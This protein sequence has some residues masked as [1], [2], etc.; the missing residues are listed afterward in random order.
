MGRV[1]NQTIAED[2]L[3][4]VFVRVWQHI[5]KVS[6]MSDDHLRHWMFIAAA[7][8]VA[9]HFRW[10]SHQR[11]LPLEYA[12]AISN[13][14]DDR[15]RQL[16]EAIARLPE[17]MRLALSMTVLGGATSEEVGQFLG[18]PAGTIRYLVSEARKRLAQEILE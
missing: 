13:Q 10:E 2:L 12:E 18:K 16:N 3:Q 4:R 7:N 11:S 14:P 9:D 6:Q 17:D 8:L 1:G 5:E 15:V